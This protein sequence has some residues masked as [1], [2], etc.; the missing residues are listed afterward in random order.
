MSAI[1][2]VDDV[3]QIVYRCEV[4][5]QTI[6]TVLHARVEV[7]GTGA[8]AEEQLAK[9][10]VVCS[11]SGAFPFLTSYAVASG[12]DYFFDWV[13]V[14]KVKPTRTIYA[15]QDINNFGG[16]ANVCGPQNIA[17]SVLKQ[18]LKPGRKGIGRMQFGGLPEGVAAGNID[19]AYIAA[20]LDPLAASMFGTFLVPLAGA[21]ALK[22]CLPAGGVDHDYDIWDAHPQTSTRTMH[23]RTVGLGI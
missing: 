14:Q 4:H 11:N 19:P 13:Q 10:A 17:A 5:S 16:H 23:R 18:S 1:L 6:L 2:A 12:S 20:F 3:L 8:S 7:A 15:R 9:I 22:W 21:L